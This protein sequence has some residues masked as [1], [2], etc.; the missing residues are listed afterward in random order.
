MQLE[1]QRQLTRAVVMKLALYEVSTR[2]HVSLEKRERAL[3]IVLANAV[4]IAL[5]KVERSIPTA[6]IQKGQLPSSP[7]GIIQ[8]VY[9][10]SE[11]PLKV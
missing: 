3:E 6:N 2:A 5:R 9:L 11:S 4:K 10:T 8:W 1:P 7:H